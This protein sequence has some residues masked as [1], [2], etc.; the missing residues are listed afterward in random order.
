MREI[1]AEAGTI[2]RR[3]PVVIVPP[4]RL[5][6]LDVVKLFVT[7]VTLGVLKL[8]TEKLNMGT[9][10]LTLKFELAAVAPFPI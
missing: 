6:E 10:L 2:T 4:F 1:I 8:L 5:R 7:S 9:E 3:E